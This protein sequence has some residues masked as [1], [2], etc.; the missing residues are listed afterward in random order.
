MLLAVPGLT[1][2]GRTTSLLC[3]KSYVSVMLVTNLAR[4]NATPPALI[5]HLLRQP[6]VRRQQHLRNMLLQHPNTPSDAKRRM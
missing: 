1:F 6:M 3:S 5:A 2:D 4:F